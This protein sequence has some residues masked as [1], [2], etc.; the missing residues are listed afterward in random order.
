MFYLLGG[1]FNN[2]LVWVSAIRKLDGEIIVN[3]A[4]VK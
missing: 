1:T 3:N 2:S 4:G